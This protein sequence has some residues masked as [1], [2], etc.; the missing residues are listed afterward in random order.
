VSREQFVGI[1]AVGMAASLW[2]TLGFF[3]KV[4][5]AE[6]VSFEAL[7]A[8]RA[9]IGWAAMLLFVLSTKGAGGLRVARGDFLFL[10]PLGLVGIGAFYL[11][12]FFT[13]R[14]STVG[15]AAILLYSSPAF[16]VLLAWLFLRE[17]LGTL[18]LLALALTLGGIFLVVGAYDPAALE[19][20]P[21]VLA[22]G[23]LSGLTYGL[24][25]I[26]GKPLAGHLDPAI[27]LSYALGVG[28]VLLVLAA[29]PTLHTLVGLSFGSYALLFMLAV[30]HTSLAFGLYTVGL[31]RLDAGQAAIVATVEPVVAGALGVVLLGE[32]L[33]APK[34]AGAFLV[35]AGAALAQV[36]FGKASRGEAIPSGSPSRPR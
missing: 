23:L 22:T 1:L 4:L 18:R 19:V 36:R 28:A 34:L 21:L 20:S 9:S 33:T 25:S 7:V 26:F 17:T 14:E 10:V 32:A 16:V 35:L 24:Y 8:V 11:L 15:T 12:Y 31:R 30:V 27:I 2:G 6:G 29:L 13:V 5:Y 3:A